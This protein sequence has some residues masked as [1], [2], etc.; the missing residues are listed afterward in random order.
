MEEVVVNPEQSRTYVSNERVS[1]W[2][3]TTASRV[4]VVAGQIAWVLST[5]GFADRREIQA[6]KPETILPFE[7][8]VLPANEA[9]LAKVF[10]GYVPPS[11]EML[12]QHKEYASAPANY[13]SAP[14]EASA[15]LVQLTKALDPETAFVFGTAR[16]RLEQLI[17]QNSKAAVVT[18]DLP[19]ELVGVAPGKPDSNN[20]RYREKIGIDSDSK[21]GD[22]VHTDA[23]LSKRVH[24]IL[25]DS[26]TFRPGR[27]ENTMRLIV[28]DGNHQLP[29]CLMDLA[30][31]LCMAHEDGAV[32]MVDDF[33][34][35]SP[36]NSGVDGAVANFS[37]VTG[38]PALM[39]CPR[40]G[41][42]GLQA[43]AAIIVVPSSY[44]QKSEMVSALRSLASLLKSY[45]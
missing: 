27:L 44:E 34:K 42:Q 21:I 26:F 40:P 23:E 5:H 38:L 43:S 19:T 22:I 7:T 30:N 35:G 6:V 45:K 39:P 24:Q 8:A 9:V 17:A 25:G 33:R 32:I 10:P 29:N 2:Q 3:D 41:E 4:E 13:G 18:I 12:V 15:F 37:Q 31:A 36:L 1:A 11:P 14:G 16:G 28:V 20:I